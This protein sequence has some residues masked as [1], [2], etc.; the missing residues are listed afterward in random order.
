MWQREIL[1][2][3]K[4]IDWIYCVEHYWRNKDKVNREVSIWKWISKYLQ[5]GDSTNLADKGK[6]IYLKRA[7]SR[8]EKL[9]LLTGA[10]KE[11]E[12]RP[13]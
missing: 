4:G 8:P 9:V 13:Y 7:I 5:Q 6:F 3:E 11:K 10:Q 1:E 2:L 12:K